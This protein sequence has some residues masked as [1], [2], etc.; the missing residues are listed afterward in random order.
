MNCGIGFKL[1]QKTDWIC[2]I[3]PE[4]NKYNYPRIFTF[5]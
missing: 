4:Y 1:M 5:L 2:A 3:L